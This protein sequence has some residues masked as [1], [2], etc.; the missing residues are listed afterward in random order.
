MSNDNIVVEVVG[1]R[2]V[3]KDFWGRPEVVAVGGIDFDLRQG[4]VLGLLGPNGSGKSTT[5][6]LL[7]GLLKPNSG[8]VK[9]FDRSPENIRMRRRIGYLPEESYLYKNIT[10]E[11]TLNFFGALF[12]LPSRERRKRTSELLEMVGLR[13][14]AKRPLAEFSKGMTR[15]IGLAQALINDPDLIILDEPTAGLDP[16]GCRDVKKLIRT[17]ADRNKSIIICSH[18]LADVENICDTAV[19]LYGG[20][21]HAK[22]PL[23][24]LLTVDDKTRITAPALDTATTA[25][26]LEILN[27]S[28]PTEACTVDKPK[29]NLEEYFWAVVE[30]ARTGNDDSSGAIS[31]GPVAPYLADGDDSGRVREKV[32]ETLTKPTITA[33]AE[34]DA[35][36]DQVQVVD[37]HDGADL[38]R[39]NKL[40]TPPTIDSETE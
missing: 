15:R 28:F 8:V 11:E 25:R 35:L 31:G 6:K 32:L 20:K 33:T 7:L 27:Q 19:I 1:L 10:A 39:L 9:I 12:N 17:L 40:A 24:E 13:H 5:I 38:D 26:V 4:E 37:Q 2:K 30:A 36:Q 16:I 22:G 29:M 18:L 23:N 14:A 21:I 3:F 34:D